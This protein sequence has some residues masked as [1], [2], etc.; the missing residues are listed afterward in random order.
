M[1]LWIT[2][3]DGGFCLIKG[4]EKTVIEWAR[5]EEITTYKIDLFSYDSTCIG[6]RVA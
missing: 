5:I 1:S 6:L 2:S 4:H 3:Y